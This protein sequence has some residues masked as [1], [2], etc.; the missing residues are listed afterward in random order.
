LGAP[1][2]GFFCYVSATLTG[3]STAATTTLGPAAT[4]GSPGSD[5]DIP[6]FSIIFMACFLGLLIIGAAAAVIY[7]FCCRAHS[8]AYNRRHSYQREE[9]AAIPKDKCSEEEGQKEEL[10]IDQVSDVSANT[11]PTATMCSLPPA[12][13]LV[14]AT[15]PPGPVPEV[16]PAQEVT[17]GRLKNLAFD[18]ALS[19]DSQASPLEKSPCPTVVADQQLIAND[20]ARAPPALDSARGQGPWSCACLS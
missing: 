20:S 13:S 6:T 4:T 7:K 11:E 14:E 9:A 12:V 8:D 3:S 17:P 10:P 15:L 16:P 2:L 19:S 1:L 18:A 5:R